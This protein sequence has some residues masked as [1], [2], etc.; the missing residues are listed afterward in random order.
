MRK[1]L[2][3]TLLTAG[4]VTVIP[5]PTAGAAP[6]GVMGRGTGHYM[7]PDEQTACLDCMRANGI[8][9]ANVCYSGGNITQPAAPGPGPGRNAHCNSLLNGSG[10]DFSGVYQA[11]CADALAGGGGPPC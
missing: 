3:V 2:F 7:S 11:C 10:N 6:C 8:N 9:A 4:F 1:L 5:T